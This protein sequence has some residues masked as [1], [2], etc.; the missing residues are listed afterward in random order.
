MQIVLKY[1][2]SIRFLFPYVL[3]LGSVFFVYDL[4]AEALLP[5]WSV[6]VAH[7]LYI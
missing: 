1:H 7:S 6:V 4:T 3:L 5:Y 2:Y